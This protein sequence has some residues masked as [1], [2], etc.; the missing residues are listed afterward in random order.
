[1]NFGK[2][3]GTKNAPRMFGRD[4]ADMRVSSWWEY[5]F[6]VNFTAKRLID[7]AIVVHNLLPCHLKLM[8]DDGNCI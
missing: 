6:G 5:L 8:Y 4:D 3:R 2:K 7:W 1:M